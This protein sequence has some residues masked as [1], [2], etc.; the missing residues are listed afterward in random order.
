MAP[1]TSRQNL[2]VLRN[3]VFVFLVLAFFAVSG[4]GG[5]EEATQQAGSSQGSDSTEAKPYDQALTNFVGEKQADS[6]QKAETA[7][8]QT[9]VQTA[10]VDD[11]QKQMEML[12]ADNT[13]LRQ[14]NLKLEDDV[15]KLTARL[16]DSEAK[17]A[18]EKDRADKAEEAA[19]TAAAQ[20][21]TDVSKSESTMK[22][23]IPMA[24]YEE[25]LGAF[26]SK[27][28]ADAAA[29][30]QKMLD[31]KVPDEIA[32]N[33]HYWIGESKYAQKKYK[34]AMREFEEVMTFKRSEKKGDAQFMLAQCYERTGDKAKAKEAFEKVVK[35]YP[36]NANVKKAKARWARL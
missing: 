21:M 14:K 18:A 17:Y 31:E 28:Y 27:K 13:D 9:Q 1:S 26:K 19:K 8:V 32:D 16:N 12:K 22:T 4:C 33:C 24:E 25:A 3:V 29:S 23:D 7:P 5:S 11:A 30:F 6:T 15:Q 36:M 10:P 20:P 35:D 34:E 2:F